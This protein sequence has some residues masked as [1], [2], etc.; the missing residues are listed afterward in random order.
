M[1]ICKRVE[2]V[3]KLVCRQVL[4]LEV[5]S[6]NAPVQHV[7]MKAT[8]QQT[9]GKAYQFTKYAVV[10]YPPVALS[11]TA[12]DIS[13]AV[14]IEPEKVGI[15]SENGARERRRTRLLVN[16]NMMAVE[17]ETVK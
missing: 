15:E 4:R 14:S 10:L 9:S 11:T 2:N 8:K 12:F 3:C 5:A 7:R 17:A 1:N 16:P 6:V 13:R